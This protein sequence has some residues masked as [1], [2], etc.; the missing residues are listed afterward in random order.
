M[1]HR[2]DEQIDDNMNE[3]TTL[4]KQIEDQ[5]LRICSI[6]ASKSELDQR[7]QDLQIQC[8]TM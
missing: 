1:V 7:F 6:E 4:R 8:S 5:H 2:R 3:I